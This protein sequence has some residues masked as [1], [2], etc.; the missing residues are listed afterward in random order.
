LLRWYIWTSQGCK[1]GRGGKV[2]V[3][4]IDA[5][6]G[7]AASVARAWLILGYQRIERLPGKKKE[8]S[9]I[10]L[11]KKGGESSYRRKDPDRLRLSC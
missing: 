10:R 5:H 11:K 4:V 2:A 6:H 7:I 1:K 9:I 8:G 3:V